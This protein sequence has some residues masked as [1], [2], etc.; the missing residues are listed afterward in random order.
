[1]KVY[2]VYITEKYERLDSDEKS[3]SVY[4]IAKTAS[5]AVAKAARI[6]KHKERVGF[7]EFRVH[8]LGIAQ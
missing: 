8:V 7:T 3:H 2:R 6:S 5:Q 1:M 4:V